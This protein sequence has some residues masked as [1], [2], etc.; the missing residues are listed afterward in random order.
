[1]P[2]VLP[3]V[4]SKTPA[5]DPPSAGKAGSA[6]RILVATDFSIRSRRALRRASILARDHA[7]A[8]LRIL[9]VVDG[10]RPGDM[11]HSDLV[12]AGRMLAE[13]IRLMPDLDGLRCRALVSVGRPSEE[14]LR[15]A[16]LDEAK[17][18]VIGTHRKRF[19]KEMVSDRTAERVL[20]GARCPVLFVDRGAS[21]SYDKVLVPVDTSAA[22]ERALRAADVMGLLR[23]DNVTLL[24]GFTAFAKGKLMLAGI[25]RDEIVD[26][27]ASE[28]EQAR[29]AVNGFLASTGL[30][31]KPWTLR[32]AEGGPFEVIAREVD[33]RPPDLMV[34][35]TSG[36][37]GL[38]RMLLGSVTE[39]AVR[40]LEVDILVMPSRGLSADANWMVTPAEQRPTGIASH[41]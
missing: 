1:M 8:E 2:S 17:L 29:E 31:D 27:I 14:I 3:F 15:I 11:I 20:R 32:V 25:R 18:I 10:G 6:L 13:Q 4:F 19:L 7:D 21:G 23:S 38:H 16:E 24:H 9:H 39:E 30:G 5:N 22:S 40:S 34:I 36:R 26:Y 33:R 12:E 41:G 28:R 35:G 37:T